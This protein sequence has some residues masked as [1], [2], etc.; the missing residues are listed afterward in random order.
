MINEPD[1]ISVFSIYEQ[2]RNWAHASFDSKQ[3]LVPSGE[4]R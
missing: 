4:A 2:N 3:K 1:D